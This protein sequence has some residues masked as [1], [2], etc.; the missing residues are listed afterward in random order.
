M[1]KARAAIGGLKAM[2]PGNAIDALKGH[3]GCGDIAS[4]AMDRLTAQY[5][6]IEPTAARRLFLFKAR[7]SALKSSEKPKTTHEFSTIAFCSMV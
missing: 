2:P 7:N 6:A 5:P 4:S 3:D 1:S